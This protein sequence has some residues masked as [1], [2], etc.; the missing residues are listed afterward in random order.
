MRTEAFGNPSL[1]IFLHA[2]VLLQVLPDEELSRSDKSLKTVPGLS[3]TK[4][5]CGIKRYKEKQKSTMI[6]P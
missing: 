4:V 1:H 2:S 5:L 6:G 3:V